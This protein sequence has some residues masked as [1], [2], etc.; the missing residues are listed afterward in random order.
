MQIVIDISEDV[1]EGAKSSP[2]YYPTYHFEKIWRT[3]VKGTPL[4]KGHG[5]LIDADELKKVYDERIS[6]LYALNKKDNPSRETRICA[7][8][9]CTNTIDELPAIIES[10]KEQE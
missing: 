9:W 8:N 7:L 10:D 4:P 2:N 6:R 1:I 3:I 5:R